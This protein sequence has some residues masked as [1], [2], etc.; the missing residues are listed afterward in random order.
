MPGC[1]IFH[2]DYPDNTCE[3]S[4]ECFAAEGER[5]DV[6]RGVCTT[7]DAA[8]EVDATPIPDGP[9]VPDAR[10]PDAQVNDAQVTDAM[11][12]DAP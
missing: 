4:D 12:I 8:P 7:T 10:I 9:L 11:V 6:E 3:S 5:C 1:F 2:D